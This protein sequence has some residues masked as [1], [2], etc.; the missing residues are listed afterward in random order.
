MLHLLLPNK[1]PS[2]SVSITPYRLY[3]FLTLGR[4]IGGKASPVSTVVEEILGFLCDGRGRTMATLDGLLD[5]LNLS[6]DP[7]DSVLPTYDAFPA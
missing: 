5:G 1:F 6:E 7:S 3:H 2:F 4:L